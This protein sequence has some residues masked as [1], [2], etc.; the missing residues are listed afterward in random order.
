M[1]VYLIRHGQTSGNIAGRHQSDKTDITELGKQQAKGAAAVVAKVAPTHL[2]TSSMLRAVETARIVGEVCDMIPE[3]TALFAEIEKPPRLNGH[4]LK[5]MYS[6]WFY[7]RWYL[8]FTSKEEGGE[9]Y[10]MFRKRLQEARRFL[11]ALPPHARVVVV[12]HSAFINFFVMHLCDDR[13][14]GPIRAL[15]CFVR[16]ITIKNGSVTKLVY[17]FDKPSHRCGWHIEKQGKE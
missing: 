4:L 17:D 11:L 10:K 3:T 8:G 13:P 5:S 15:Q 16:I 1:E 12:S 6:I 14:I 2:Y 7:T 9:S